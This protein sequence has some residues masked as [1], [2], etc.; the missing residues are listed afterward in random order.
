MKVDGISTKLGARGNEV[1][2][3]VYSTLW[4][5]EEIWKTLGSNK[6]D[7]GPRYTNDTSLNIQKFKEGM[8]SQ[9]I[10]EQARQRV[11]VR[12]ARGARSPLADPFTDN[13]RG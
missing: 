6:R 13:S 3:W 7:L 5:K 8:L 4:N 11:Q 10:K 1:L 12:L 9:I 2:R